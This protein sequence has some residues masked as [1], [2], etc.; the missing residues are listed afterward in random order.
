[1]VLA[2]SCCAVWFSRAG[3]ERLVKVEPKISGAMYRDIF[4]ENLLQSSL[5][6]KL[7]GRFIFQ[8]DNELK[9]GQDNKRIAVGAL[10]E[11]A[12]ADQSD[13]RLKR[14]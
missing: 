7:L 5:D 6:L 12:C 13:P 9:Q 11:C 3:T 10:Y 4:D 8:Q 2:A 1:M 14:Y